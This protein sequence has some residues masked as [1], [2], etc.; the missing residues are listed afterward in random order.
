MTETRSND[1]YEL[2]EEQM[3]LRDMLHEFADQ[4]IAPKAARYDEANEFPW[5]N[6]KKMRDLGL[7]GMI[8]P[9]E[10]GGQGLDT[11]SYVI[12]VEEISRACAST[13]ITLAAHVSLGT[14]P[15]FNFGTAEQKRKYLPALCTGEKLAAFGLTE[16]E[17]GSDAGGT[18]TRA[19]LDQ[20]TYT[21]NGRKI[22]ITNGSVCGTAVFTAVTTPGIG[23]KGISAFII[24]KGT[25]GFSAGTR[26]KKLGHRASDTVELLFENVKLPKEN[27]LEKDGKE[28]E[29]FKQ[30][31]KTLDGGRISIGAMSVGIA[32][33]SLDA[34]IKYARERRQFGKP[35]AEFQAIQLLL[36]D[37][38]TGIEASRLLV[39][40]TARLKDRGLP[41]TRQSA[42]AKLLA[43]TVAM[44]AADTAIQIHGGAGYMT[45]HPVERYFRDAKLM[46]IGEGTSQI[47]KLVIARELLRE[48]EGLHGRS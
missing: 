40:Q 38:A 27:L 4:E 24:E 44:K 45:D 47:Q 30:F 11:L 37:M 21:V 1:L 25:P 34:A 14:S 29:G 43:S 10:Y 32:Q 19:V 5:D 28:G 39:Y 15:I 42:M 6:I 16:P 8:F 13:G 9:E 48:A 26:E 22:Y 31:M 41:F 7:F 33:A 23:V 36:A 35:I 3:R 18:K 20:G 46:E 12:A 17:A 2:T